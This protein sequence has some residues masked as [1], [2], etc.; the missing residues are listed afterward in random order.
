VI[1]GM[2]GLEAGQSA[3][4]DTYAWFRDLLSWPLN[5]LLSGSSIIDPATAKRL[6]DELRSRMLTQLSEEASKLNVSED[7]ELALDWFNGRRTPDANQEL[8]AAITGLDLASD[9][10]AIFLALAEATCFGARKIVDRFNEQGVTVQG[11][12]GLGGV[13]KKSPFIMQMMA[14]VMN[15]PIRI[16]RSEQACA[17]GAAMFAATAAGIYTK[18]EDAMAAMGSGFEKEYYPNPEKWAI[19]EKRYQK[20]K[21]LAVVIEGEM[22]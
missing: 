8:K 9:A 2:T 7:S 21:R 16:H 12:I 5:Y 6:K 11:L 13:A 1:P 18:V 22:K 15:M 3:F 4:G 19:Y 17:T 14:N 20:F 10:P